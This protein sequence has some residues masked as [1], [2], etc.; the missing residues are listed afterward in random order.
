[1]SQRKVYFDESGNTGFDLLN[2]DQRIYILCSTDIEESEAKHQ[3]ANSFSNIENLHFKKT[4]R[5][6]RGADELLRFFDEQVIGLNGRF[7]SFILNKEYMIVSQMLNYL[8]EPQ[9]YED[10]IDYY[11]AGM[12][13]AHANVV[14][15]GLPLLCERGPANRLY[16]AFIDMFNQKTPATTD[17]FY[18]T[19]SE[20]AV[21]CTDSDFQTEL[22][23]LGRSIDQLPSVLEV[24]N[25]YVLD[26]AMHA[27]IDLA[28]YWNA[29][30]PQGFK[31]VHDRSNSIKNQKEVLDFLVNLDTPPTEVG[32]GDFKVTYPLN[33]R[34]FTFDS[35]ETNYS[36]KLC[37]IICSGLF[38]SLT[39]PSSGDRLTPSLREI[40]KSWKFTNT[41]IPTLDVEPM[42]SRKK[43][44]G[45]I[46]SLDFLARQVLKK[47]RKGSRG[48]P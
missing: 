19:V 25:K 8:V 47:H 32:Y 1:M 3:L 48:H 18:A 22:L 45:D 23:I 7:K 43:R 31:I 16:K 39:A 37:D 4:R 29:D 42:Q 21:N 13:I 11:D 30:F 26:P 28:G 46:D 36:I 41:V 15:H 33:I 24:V 44:S 12:N 27:L 38:A 10:G 5:S 20:L 2:E 40:L 35:A 34:D 17:H 6:K 9:L 14:F